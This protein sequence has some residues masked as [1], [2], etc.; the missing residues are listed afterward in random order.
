MSSLL[1]EKVFRFL[2]TFLWR[3][4]V[5]QIE[6]LYLQSIVLSAPLWMVRVSVS[7]SVSVSL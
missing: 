5:M 1:S 3:A 4:S 6:L 7:V 2:F